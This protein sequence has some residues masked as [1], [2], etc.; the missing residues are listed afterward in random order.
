MT[1]IYRIHHGS[2]GSLDHAS[3][4]PTP[5]VIR[6]SLDYMWSP[7]DGTPQTSKRAY[8]RQ[9]KEAGCEIHDKATVKDTNRPEYDASGLKEEIAQA[10]RA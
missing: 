5:S 9:L 7:I 4:L 3:D 8:Y 1:V 10:L 2:G 6:D